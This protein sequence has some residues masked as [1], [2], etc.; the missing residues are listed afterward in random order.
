MKPRHLLKELEQ[1]AEALG[2]KVRTQSFRG[3]GL[4]V[5]GLCKLKGQPVVLLNLRVHEDERALALGAILRSMDTQALQLSDEAREFLSL[6]QRRLQQPV[7]E[8]F[9][10]KGPGLKRARP[11]R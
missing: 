10:S 9:R 2:L 3:S 5:G 8:N 4:S 7:A 11:K 6:P 1:V